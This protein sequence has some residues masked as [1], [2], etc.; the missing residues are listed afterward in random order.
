MAQKGQHVRKWEKQLGQKSPDSNYGDAKYISS[1]TVDWLSFTIP[2]GQYRKFDRRW[3]WEQTMLDGGRF[4]YTHSAIVLEVG[5]VMWNPQ[6]PDMGWHYSLPASALA[7]V[8][9]LEQL[10][11]DVFDCDGHFSRIDTCIDE[12]TGAVTIDRMLQALDDGHFSSRWKSHS[13][14]CKTTHGEDAT[15]GRT[16]YFGTRSSSSFCRAYDKRAERIAKTG[17]DC[18]HPWLRLEYEWKRK[19]ADVIAQ[20]VLDGKWE[21]L[22]GVMLSYLSFLEPTE[23]SNKSR[24]PVAVWWR[25]F[26]QTVEKVAGL[27]TSA[28]ARTV[29]DV[30]GWLRSQ[31]GPSLAILLEVNGGDLGDVTWL[32]NEGRKRWKSRHRAILA[33]A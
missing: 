15:T 14:I 10:M 16:L 8:D 5:R 19:A 29:D 23:D 22:R 9:D 20:L 4:G 24:W 27:F 21:A 17:E 25:E 28:T 11:R 33:T 31:V 3:P 1:L 32:A 13:T 2:V 6:R 7:Q 12:K 26:L 30:I 18:G